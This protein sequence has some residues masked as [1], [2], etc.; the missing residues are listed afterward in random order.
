MRARQPRDDVHVKLPSTKERTTSGAGR[1]T[2]LRKKWF[3]LISSFSFTADINSNIS[4][5]N[6]LLP[7]AD[8]KE[9]VQETPVVSRISDVIEVFKNDSGIL[10]RCYLILALLGAFSGMVQ[11]S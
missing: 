9:T 7:A 1:T 3:D 11:Y 5:R 4:E 10:W 2:I 8:S 6:F